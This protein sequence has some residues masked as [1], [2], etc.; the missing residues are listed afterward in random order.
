MQHFANLMKVRQF[1]QEIKELF[2]VRDYQNLN[3]I[4]LLLFS[5]NIYFHV[6][7]TL[8]HLQLEC[9]QLTLNS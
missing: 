6:P 7:L 5:I 1:Y 9:I 4:F 3:I 8:L 2:F